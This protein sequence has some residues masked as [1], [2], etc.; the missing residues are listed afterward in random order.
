LSHEVTVRAWLRA[1]GYDDVAEK[2]E[3]VMEDWR[4]RGVK[5]RRN[6]WEVLA[7]GKDGIPR[8]IN[9]ITFPVLA[10]AR[11]RQGLPKEKNAL[12]HGERRKGLAPRITGRWPVAAA[13]ETNPEI[14]AVATTAGL[15]DPPSDEPPR[16]L[17][18]R[19]VKEDP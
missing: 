16:V 13:Q 11:H 9:G 8:T 15:Q 6:W 7:G 5:T 4:R 18:D 19:E 2:I 10:A 1:N 3:L 17:G 14:Q 12:S